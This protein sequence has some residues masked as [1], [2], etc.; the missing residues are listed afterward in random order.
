MAAAIDGRS[1][2]A[3]PAEILDALTGVSLP[4]SGLFEIVTACLGADDAVVKSERFAKPDLARVSLRSGAEVWWR[5]GVR[6]CGRSAAAGPGPS[7]NIRAF[8]AIDRRS[9]RL[10]AAPGQPARRAPI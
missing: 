3:A 10:G 1:C 4:P 7:S 5:P 6:R 2:A 8:P 9:V